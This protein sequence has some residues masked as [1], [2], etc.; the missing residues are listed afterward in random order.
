MLFIRFFTSLCLGLSVTL[1]SPSFA[2]GPQGHRVAGDMAWSYLDA[3]TKSR[4]YGLLEEQTLAD[5]STWA[6]RMRS[7]NSVYWQETAKPYHYV[8][9]PEGKTY[10]DVGA[11]SEGDAV[12]AL[13]NF[14]MILADPGAPRVQRQLAL[15]F[16]LHIVQDLHQPFHV[17]NGKDRGGNT[18]TVRYRD[19][20]INMHRLWDSTIVR[21]WNLND[22]S[23]AQLLEV[24]IERHDAWSKDSVEVWIAES[25]ALRDQIYPKGRSIDTDYLTRWS[26]AAKQRLSQA[27]VRSAAWLS[28]VLAQP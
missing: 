16:G 22:T 3:D 25:A 27:G 12:S 23:L 26:P 21:F 14:E 10:A 18:V 6:D 24:D 4:V 7:N 5:A 8:T 19:K 17:G 20:T 9:V 28:K 2:W 15:R 11:P 1:S 13:R